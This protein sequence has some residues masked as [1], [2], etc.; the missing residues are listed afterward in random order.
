MGNSSSKSKKSGNKNFKDL[1]DVVDYIATYYIL[2]MDFQSLK[3]LTEKEYCD[4]L[5]VLTGDI[6]KK[7]FND[8]D[9]T[10]LAQRIKN[11][12]EV[13][14]LMKD[15]VTFLSKDQFDIL[16]IK[17]DKNKSIKK[18]R[19]CIGIA[20]FYIK[21]A[22]LFSAIVT[23]INPVYTYRDA[24]GN[25][26]EVPLMEKNT[27]PK[28][29][30]RTLKKLNICE[31]RIN[32]LRNKQSDTGV[33]SDQEVIN[34]SICS[35]NLDA[36]HNN[37]TLADEPG[38]KELMNLY[39]DDNY[40]YSTGMFTGMSASTKA[41]F[42]HDLK[43]FYTAFTGKKDMPPEYQSFS[44]IKLKDFNTM[45]GCQGPDPAYEKPYLLNKNDKLFVKYAEN[46]KDMIKSATMRQNELLEIINTIFTH[47]DDSYSGKQKIRVNPKLTEDILQA[48]VV[49]ARQIIIK[50]YVGCEYDFIE[51]LKIYEAIVNSKII[52]T[53]ESQV[54]NL[55]KVK[56]ETIAKSITPQLL[57]TEIQ[58]PPLQNI[59]STIPLTTPLQVAPMPM[60][61]P[62]MPMQA[63]Q[64]PIQVRPPTI[65]VA[66]MPIQ[67]PPT[68]LQAPLEVETDSI[69]SLKSPETNTN[70]IVA[71]NPGNFQNASVMKNL[72]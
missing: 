9:I 32:S 51:G 49:K 37:K 27:I 19:V 25:V 22:H 54:K 45:N 64:M 38:I 31:N 66:P 61:A 30:P 67:A 41:I 58:Q 1:Y 20:K 6:I 52:Q 33:S 34:P 40:D 2:T 42:L 18:K 16:D 71:N 11:G 62:Q 17:N 5:V 55:N 44:D 47:V 48:T 70:R 60:Q 59:Q 26:V 12:A 56:R 46:I 14:E 69:L 63:P 39:L 3:K 36:N 7:Y 68:P 10:Y 21:I 35:L 13:N 72:E 8:L 15:H 50:L 53:T 57:S 29:V 4:N 23:T 24:N 43:T 28:N 65:P